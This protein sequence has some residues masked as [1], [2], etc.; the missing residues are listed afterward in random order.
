MYSKNKNIYWSAPNNCQLDFR[1]CIYIYI[2]IYVDLYVDIKFVLGNSLYLHFAKLTSCLRDLLQ[3]IHLLVTALFQQPKSMGKQ[4]LYE[5]MSELTVSIVSD[6]V[7][8]YAGR[9]A[10]K[11]AVDC[12]RS[13]KNR[14]C[15]FLDV[16]REDY[17]FSFLIRYGN[18]GTHFLEQT[19]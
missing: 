12:R 9:W 10:R 5:C 7:D 8:I 6:I 1:T 3:C 2:Y 4:S 13:Y 15:F 16:C 17:L 19:K 14:G 11:N 18:I